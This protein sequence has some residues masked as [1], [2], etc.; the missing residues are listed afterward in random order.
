MP[1]PDSISPRALTDLFYQSG[2][3]SRG[4]VT[5]LRASDP[6]RTTVSI[7]TFLD[8]TFSSDATPR[9]PSRL[10]LKRPLDE[11]SLSTEA[12]QRELDFYARLAPELPSPPLVRCFVAAPAED[13]S[14]SFLILEDLRQSHTNR[15]WPMPPSRAEGE[16]AIEALAQ[17]HATWWQA[18]ALGMSV[19][20]PHTA[21]SLTS[22]VSTIAAH[23]PEFLDEVGY[24]LSAQRRQTLERVFGSRLRP[25]LR[26][27]DP[28]ALTVTHGDAHGW[29]FLFPREIGSAAYLV[30]W[31]L[32]HV[33]VGARD[34]AYMIAFHYYPDLRRATEVPLLQTY[35]ERLH[36][37]GIDD[38]TWE[39]L[40]LDYRRCVVRNL[41]IPI[42]LWSRGL[43]PEAWWHRLECAIAAYE[44][45]HCDD[46]L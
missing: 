46:L 21:E 22:M 3:L 36:V 39:A 13:V 34:L 38:Y 27:L 33:D 16:L 14:R 23:L 2:A 41:T 5:E 15:P 11:G 9:V 6:L 20:S 30:D 28:R 19:G 4:T 35:V 10:V 12:S 18:P 42:L 25:W 37:L 1:R 7:L 31:Q 8:V 17:I 43:A 45:L 24:A 26:L 40:W 29:N 44:D 32:W